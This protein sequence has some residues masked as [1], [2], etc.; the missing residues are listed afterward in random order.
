[1]KQKDKIYI[2]C[3]ARLVNVVLSTILSSTFLWKN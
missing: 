3:Q 1:M 2:L